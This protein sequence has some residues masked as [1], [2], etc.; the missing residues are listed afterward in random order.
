[1]KS[2][3]RMMYGWNFG[4]TPKFFSPLGIHQSKAGEGYSSWKPAVTIL[5]QLGPLRFKEIV[6]RKKEIGRSLLSSLSGWSLPCAQGAFS[7]AD[8][9]CLTIIPCYHLSLYSPV[10][11]EAEL[12]SRSHKCICCHMHLFVVRLKQEGVCPPE[13]PLTVEYLEAPPPHEEVMRLVPE[14]AF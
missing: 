5:N 11:P 10:L 2:S 12:S 4:G 3:L 9:Q 8:T 1:M 13:V 7:A 14:V 6:G